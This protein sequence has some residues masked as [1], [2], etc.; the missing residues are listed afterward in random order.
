[1]MDDIRNQ[2]F[3]QHLKTILEIIV[4]RLRDQ[5]DMLESVAPAY[6]AKAALGSQG[7]G[8]YCFVRVNQNVVRKLTQ[9]LL[10]LDSPRNKCDPKGIDELDYWIR[11]TTKVTFNLNSSIVP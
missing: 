11:Y 4:P 6:N 8:F 5:L 2:Q 9:S 3:T 1:M 10:F 7:N